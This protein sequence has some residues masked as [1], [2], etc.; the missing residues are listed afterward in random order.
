M[1]IS[2]SLITQAQSW[3]GILPTILD[4]YGL[5]GNVKWSSWVEISLR[6]AEELQ[7]QDGDMLL[8]E[9]PH[10]SVR[11]PPTCAHGD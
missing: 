1:L 4:C 5:Q 2:Q 9:S 11:V 3:P 10:A 8:V 6:T 7:V